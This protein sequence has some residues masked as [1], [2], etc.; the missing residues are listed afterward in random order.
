[1]LNDRSNVKE[2]LAVKVLNYRSNVMEVQA[3]SILKLLTD[4][5]V[6]RQIKCDGSSSSKYSKIIIN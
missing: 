6:E 4:T 5:N 2:V 1:M 3:A